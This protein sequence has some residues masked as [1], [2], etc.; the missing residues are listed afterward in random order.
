MA[1]DLNTCTG[2]NAC[3]VACYAENNV[4][5][6][7]EEMCAKGREMSWIRV[8]RYRGAFLPMLCQQCDEAPCESVCPVTATY[9]NPEGLNAQVYNRCIGTRFCSNNCPY[10]VRR[11]NFQ[12]PQ[13]P[14]PLDEQLNP[15]VTV[16]SAGV[17][18]K[19]TF[20][21]QR[22]QEAKIAAK[23]HAKDSSDVRIPTDSF[24]VACAQ[25]CSAG[26]IKFGNKADPKSAV[27]QDIENGRTYRLLDYLGVKPRVH[28]MARVMNPNHAMPD[29]PKDEIHELKVASAK[30]GAQEKGAK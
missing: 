20:C 24:T 2:C 4:P 26:A 1:I 22:V 16:R 13:W 27:N 5:T 29:A 15:D 6:V 10:K 18:E 9:H 12:Q 17:M 11:F 3:V 30:E 28:Y 14:S 21:V 23:V 8:E 7:G 25:V 19:C